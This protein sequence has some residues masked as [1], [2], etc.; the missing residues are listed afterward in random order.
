MLTS[1]CSWTSRS[2]IDRADSSG[3]GLNDWE[4]LRRSPVPV[5]LVKRGGTWRRP[6]VLAAIDPAHGFAKPAKLDTAIMAAANLVAGALDGKL[7]VAHAWPGSSVV[8]F[9][10]LGI[11]A[12]PAIE[13]AE[14]RDAR[15]A[16]DEEVDE[17][18]LDT[19]KRH[20]VEGNPVEVIP[21]L[22]RSQAA[23]IVVM[24]AISHS[25][26][27]RLVVGNVAEQVLD[28]LPCDVLVIKPAEFKARVKPARRGVQLIATP[29]YV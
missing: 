9:D 12:T 21:R 14:R 16:F 7:Q 8:S 28:A 10:E 18:G 26:F 11:A 23:G 19:A 5:L 1:A 4:L 25:G 27:Q 17:A 2:E 13:Q 3:A 20:F 22:A 24:G 6:T 15:A 29:A